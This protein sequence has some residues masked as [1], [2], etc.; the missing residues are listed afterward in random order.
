MRC[1][2]K[3]SAST[4]C[5]ASKVCKYQCA[6]QHLLLT[7][8]PITFF[9]KCQYLSVRFCPPFEELCVLLLPFMVQYSSF[10]KCFTSVMPLFL[11]DESEYPCCFLLQVYQ[12]AQKW[13]SFTNTVAFV[14][15]LQV[16]DVYK[17]IL[18]E[19]YLFSVFIWHKIWQCKI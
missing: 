5:V 12:C 3:T 4:K 7:H 8:P 18:F 1:F 16:D 14:M 10:F 6:L 9:C 2:K 17:N 11:K 15:M 13:A 19:E